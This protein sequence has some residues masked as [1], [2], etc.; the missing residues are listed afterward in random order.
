MSDETKTYRLSLRTWNADQACLRSLGSYCEARVPVG[1][2]T[3]EARYE[4]IP[5]HPDP[6]DA[7]WPTTCDACGRP[8]Q[9]AYRQQLIL[10]G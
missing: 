10:D 5:P 2:Y 6:Q 7:R 3:C 4:P 9:D 8:I 1:T